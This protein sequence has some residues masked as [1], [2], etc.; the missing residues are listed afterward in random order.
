MS[1]SLLLMEAS[2]YGKAE[3]ATIAASFYVDAIVV[4]FRHVLMTG[5]ARSGEGR[6]AR[7]E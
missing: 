5:F 3:G 2:K 6:M 4:T 7:I 1:W